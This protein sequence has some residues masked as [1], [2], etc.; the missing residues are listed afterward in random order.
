MDELISMRVF[1]QVAESGSFV[2]AADR[3]SVSTPMVSK[4]VVALEKRLRVAASQSQQPQ[5]ESHR[6]GPAL[7]RALQDHP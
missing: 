7:F 6:A 4:H 1:R 3:L 5:V 2:G